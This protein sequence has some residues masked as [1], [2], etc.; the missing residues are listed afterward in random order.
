MA[1]PLS[2]EELFA[3]LEQRIQDPSCA[4]AQDAEVWK[5]SGVE[6]AVMVVDLSGFSRLTRRHGILHFLTIYRRACTIATP[7]I[8]A[9]GGRVVKCMADNV[10]ATFPHPRA[11]IE[12][13]RALVAETAA[14]DAVLPADDR[15]VVCVGIGYGRFLALADD[16][17][18]DEVNLAFKLGEDIARGREILL[19][20]DA[21]AKLVA[22]GD[23]VAADDSTIELGGVRL[24]YFR[25]TG[26]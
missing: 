1:S 12:A 10:I 11:A 6:A 13:A 8:A 14:L 3:L 22:D 16:I 2:R 26:A 5:T 24:R 18:G 15:V 7:L 17:Y 4:R 20:E 23:A 25:L 21:H 9:Y 19:T